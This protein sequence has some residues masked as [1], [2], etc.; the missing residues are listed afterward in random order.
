MK[1]PRV[2]VPASAVLFLAIEV[3][4]V[5]YLFA[6]RG[7]S[8]L[9]L[10]TVAGLAI[11]FYG[12]LG[13]LAG[14]HPR[15][16]GSPDPVRAPGLELLSIGAAYVG[17]IL[18]IFSISPIGLPLFFGGLVGWIG[19]VAIS[20]YRPGEV[21]WLTRSWRPF[22]PLLVGVTAPKLFLAGPGLLFG[23]TGGVLSGIFQQVILQ[24][25]ATAR[26]E[27]ATRRPDVAAVVA[28]LCFALVHVPLNLPMAG[29]DWAIALANAAVLQAPI[30]LAFCLAY[31]RHRAP[32]ALGAV[33]GIVIA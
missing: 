7:P 27:A 24:L 1:L 23:L 10:L 33:H 32:L 19:A 30:G 2:S 3:A 28:A 11:L 5:A 26:L 25:G 4:A 21:A 18:W 9:P 16:D 13:W 8:I 17:Y 22:V 20:G 15:A 14:R 6:R 29:G 12:V 31:Q